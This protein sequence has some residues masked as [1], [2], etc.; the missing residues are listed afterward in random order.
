MEQLLHT[1]KAYCMTIN[2]QHMKELPVM[3]TEGQYTL[4]NH[5]AKKLGASM[6]SILRFA[7]DRYFKSVATHHFVNINIFGGCN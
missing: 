4:L 3:L 5:E 1:Y 7:L 6:I 2:L